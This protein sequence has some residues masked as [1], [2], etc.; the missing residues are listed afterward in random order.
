[1][2][3]ERVV[4]AEGFVLEARI[5]DDQ[6]FVLS[7]RKGKTVLVEYSNA[8]RYEFKS[9]EKLR[10]DFERDAEDALRQG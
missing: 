1:M 7:L 8:S 5:F 6:G 3:E 10:Y 4:L 9:V 2:F